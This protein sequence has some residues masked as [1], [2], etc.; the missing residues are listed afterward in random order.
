[1][2]C[3][4]LGKEKAKECALIMH[5]QVTDQHGTDLEALKTMSLI[6]RLYEY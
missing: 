5:T 2:F 4:K 3:D 1:M 6:K